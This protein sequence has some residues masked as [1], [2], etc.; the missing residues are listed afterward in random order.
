M[1]RL[2]PVFLFIFI[3]VVSFGGILNF[4]KHQEQLKTQRNN[5]AETISIM[6]D[7]QADIIEKLG[8]IFYEQSG[9]QIKIIPLD[10]EAIV[11]GKSGSAD[12]YLSSQQN[13]SFLKKKNKLESYSSENT[14]TIL[15]LFKDEEAFWT[16]LWIDPIIFA[17]NPGFDAKHPNFE[18]SWTNVFINDEIKLSLTDF[19][20]TEMSE[21][22]LM[23]LVEHF[24]NIETFYLLDRGQ[25]HIL[26]YGKYLSTPARMAGMGKCDIG[27]SSYNEAKRIQREKIPVLTIYPTDG[28]PWYLYGVG[29]S[30]DSNHP[31]KAKQFINWLLSP[32]NYKNI[33]RE[34]GYQYIFVNDIDET[35]DV[36]GGKLQYWELQKKYDNKGKDKLLNQWME[37]IRFGRN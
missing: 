8:I 24:G 19:I 27:I 10:K 28:V 12:I 34:N 5:R 15:N 3:A 7:I 32:E 21:D 18:Y 30:T 23:S 33:M 37:K 13:L 25:S 31:Y 36:H 1:K 4:A 2:I 17:V 16:G 9:I 35:P 20:A 11:S 26:Q 29:L 6:T 22:F 14:D